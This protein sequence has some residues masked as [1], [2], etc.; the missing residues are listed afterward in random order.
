MRLGYDYMRKKLARLGGYSTH[1]DA[2]DMSDL[3]YFYYVFIWSRRMTRLQRSRPLKQNG[4]N[5]NRYELFSQPVETKII[6]KWLRDLRMIGV[7]SFYVLP[8]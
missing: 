2:A 3:F 8:C 6:V 1:R 5:K 4:M 7:L